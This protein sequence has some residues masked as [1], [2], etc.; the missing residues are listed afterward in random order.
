MKS[1][2]RI[3]RLAAG[4]A[5]ILALASSAW[6]SDE[7]AAPGKPTAAVAAAPDTTAI[8][9]Q[10]DKSSYALGVEVGKDFRKQSMDVDP[11]AFLKGLK[12]ALA[13]SATLMTEGEIRLTLAEL[14]A[15]L[16]RKQGA[17][18]AEKVLAA[19]KL[20]E[21]NKADGEAFLSV[22]KAREGVVTLESGLQYKIVKAGDGKKPTVDDTVVCQYRGTLLDGTEFDSSYRRNRPATFPLKGVIK[23][24]SEAL[25]LMPVGS[26]W[27]L[28][29]PSYLAYGERGQ[30]KGSIPPNAILIFEVELAS[31]QNPPVAK[32]VENE[33]SRKTDPTR[34][35]RKP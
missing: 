9:S 2:K 1:K 27:Q 35:A 14:Q 12:D 33:T 23:G 15:E 21:K 28:F 30:P 6:A 7:N 25:Q 4:P 19:S 10:K 11:A 16:K 8:K 18:E 3:V 32:P 31:I 34:L 29:I 26:T 24:W 20:A 5:M 13:G 22:N 17:S